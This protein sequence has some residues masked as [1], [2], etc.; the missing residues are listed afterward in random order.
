MAITAVVLSAVAVAGPAAA[1]DTAPA[2]LAFYT[3]S[4]DLVAGEHGSVIW[5]RPI[6]GDPALPGARNW[7][8]LYRSVDMQ[9]QPV[10][11]SGTVAVPDGTPPAGGWPLISWAHGTTGVADV[12]AP[13]RDTGTDFPAHDY[14]SLV[15]ETQARFVAAGYAVA[16]T[17]YQGLGTPGDHGYLI[18]EAEQRAIADMAL[19][20]REVAPEI[21]TR[22]AAVGH[23]QGGQGAIF[24]A[25]LAQQWAPRLQLLGAVAEAPASH[26]GLIAQVGPLA[27]AA[28]V[29]V[30]PKAS[31]AFLPLI[32]RGAQ[33][34]ADIDPARFLTPLGQDLLPQAGDRC[35]AQLREPDSWGGQGAGD[36]FR[37]DADPSA[38]TAVLNAN[39]PSG[40]TFTPPVLVVQGTADTTVPA[41]GTD[42]MVAQQRLAG[43]PVEYRTYAG[44]DHRG[45]LAASYS[46]A[47]AWL[48]ARFGQ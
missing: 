17:D 23:S 4:A 34:V 47:Q 15:R 14:T 2:G 41:T 12:C 44:I 10:A 21:G 46:E 19:A 26:I 7:L 31:N 9:G 42:A 5:M 38:L 18:G 22:W 35:I 1:D 29:D 24:T 30:L 3:P 40:L 36:L 39:D 6:D 25:A 32:I 43:Q 48:D 20:A 11:V 37:A 28:Q 27:A 45:I 16:Q 13:S 33:T 8:V